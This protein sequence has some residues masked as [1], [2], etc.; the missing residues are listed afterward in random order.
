MDAIREWVEV[1]HGKLQAERGATD[2]ESRLFPPAAAERLAELEAELGGALP[3]SYRAFLQVSDGWLGF[4]FGL[5]LLGTGG[6]TRSAVAAA[7]AEGQMQEGGEELGRLV[8]LG[9]N[10][11]E[12]LY[13]V[14]DPRDPAAG[15]P[16]MRV[17][18]VGDGELEV[19]DSFAAMLEALSA[20]ERLPTTVPL[21][22]EA[23]F[24]EWGPGEDPAAELDPDGQER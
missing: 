13:L 23:R 21:D 16:R 7:V 15:E 1:V 22:M 11:D 10:V 2:P 9:S 14:F 6:P 24:R 12:D 5:T 18:S 19:F 17:Y 3:Q 4:W 20:G 8:V